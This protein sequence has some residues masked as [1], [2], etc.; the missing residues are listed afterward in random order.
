MPCHPSIHA[1][2][3]IHYIA[4]LGWIVRV[5]PYESTSTSIHTPNANA[6]KVGRATHPPF[7]FS[8]V[9]T[10]VAIH[11][12]FCK[13]GTMTQKPLKVMDDIIAQLTPNKLDND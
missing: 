10:C 3:F 12:S 2:S 8:F 6:Q 13:I 1:V 11:E 5:L 4:T 9:I 7:L